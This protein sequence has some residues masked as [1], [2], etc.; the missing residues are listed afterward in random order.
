[1]SP[2][3]V[4]WASVWVA[5]VAAAVASP[6]VGQVAPPGGDLVLTEIW[7]SE[8]VDWTQPLAE[9]VGVVESTPG[10][11]WISDSSPGSSSR[12]VIVREVG[13][14]ET[15]VGRPGEGPGEI[16]S[17]GQL[18]VTPEG[19]VVMYDIAGIA[20]VEY[21][22]TGEPLR[23]VRLPVQVRW[24]KGFAVI[25][26]GDFVVSGPVLGIDH[27]IHRFSQDGRLVE[28]WA[29]R[30]EASHWR[31]VAIATGGPLHASGDGSLLYS[32][33]TP[34]RIVRYLPPDG[35]SRSRRHERPI[36]AMSEMFQSPGDGVIVETIE[37]GEPVR[38]FY[39]TYPQSRGVF[40]MGGG[41]ILNVVVMRDEGR[42]VWQLFAASEAQ[43][44]HTVSNS[45][46]LAE[47]HVEEAYVPWFRCANGDILA[48]RLDPAT[49]VPVVVR[50]QVRRGG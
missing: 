19:S 40:E 32:Q 11:I 42:S 29:D 50:L 20:I 5:S 28:S 41:L 12:L 45:V 39:V 46:P 25:A 18:A 37:D 43:V 14:A 26:S 47:E 35:V 6:L 30:A 24:P 9:V 33:G 2:Q 22:A 48:T 13:G 36:A 1:M 44:G 17:A 27:A 4:L 49:D 38:S 16:R 3:Q 21:S 23:R 15:V 31:A 34:H 10:V 8:T 7:S